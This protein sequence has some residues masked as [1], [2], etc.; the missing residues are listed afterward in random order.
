[1]NS[2]NTTDTDIGIN[3][4]DGVKKEIAINAYARWY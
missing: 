1:L 4:F 2:R 3:R